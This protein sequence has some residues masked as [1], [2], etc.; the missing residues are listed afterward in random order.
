MTLPDATACL[1]RATP[2][3]TA[4][5]RV[6]CRS[7]AL[8][9]IAL[10]ALSVLSWYPRRHGALDMRWDASVYYVL[11]T[12]LA[13]GNG[14]RLLNEP[15]NIASNQYP[16]MLPAII[17]IHQKLVG[18]TDPFVVGPWLK[19]S[20]VLLSA[21]VIT[22][23]YFFFRRF[24]TQAWARC[25]AIAYLLSLSAYL[26]FNML[27]AELPFTVSLMV[28][29]LAHYGRR[30]PKREAVASLA[31]VAAF[32]C[33]TIGIVLFAAWIGDAL[34]RREFG[35]V[36]VRSLVAA[37]CVIPWYA[38]VQHVETAAE[39]K[40]PAYAY[41]RANYLY[42][43]V[44]YS[45]N[46]AY[47]DPYRPEL[48]IASRADLIHRVTSNVTAMPG[49]IGEAVTSYR[50]FWIGQSTAL[51]M[52]TRVRLIAPAAVDAL[53]IG[54]GC[55]VL[56]G[57]VILA[58]R[59]EWFIV[60]YLAGT[61]IAVCTTPWSQQHVR[62]M[63]PS[64]PVLFPA[65]FTAV[66]MVHRQRT[67]RGAAVWRAAGVA[68]VAVVALMIGEQVVTYYQAHTKYLLGSDITDRSGRPVIYRQL[69]YYPENVGMDE[70]I[71]WIAHHAQTSDVVA[72]SMAHWVYL[73]TGLKAV[74]PPLELDGALSTRLLD[75]VPVRYIIL[76]TPSFYAS[77]Y[78]A[79]AVQGHPGEWR[80]VYAATTEDVRVYERISAR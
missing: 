17:A 13:Q 56:C 46:I 39:Y 19:L 23:A 14:Y 79:N 29:L 20:Y 76:E 25:A 71:T 72:A 32:L 22:S 15:G 50:N 64:L 68:V 63:S 44:S 18:S 3:A 42:Y 40:L 48:G 69:F 38:W 77:K 4:P 52:R 70:C 43:N 5:D 45:K 2:D 75:S 21:F 7:D 51:N 73:R 47:I 27:S 66:V 65:F 9:A 12:S 61:V 62:Y 11:G 53:L 37:C 28:F 55:I 26:H 34:L 8:F 36:A 30:S 58:I 41:Q 35:R 31:A 24:L 16:P 54:F 49:V 1:R 33:R 74:M 57:M 67:T 59:R 60:L 78:V 10:I 6:W 80:Q